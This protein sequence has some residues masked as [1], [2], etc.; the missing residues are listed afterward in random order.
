MSSNPGAAIATCANGLAQLSFASEQR[1][2]TGDGL[3][4]D[5]DVILN[6]FND[7][8]R[9]RRDAMRDHAEN[10]RTGN[11]LINE[12]LAKIDS[13]RAEAW[14]AVHSAMFM[15]TDEAD[16]QAEI[17]TAMQARSN[18]AR[19]RYLRA[20]ANAK[21]MAFLA[22]RSIEERLGIYLSEMT[23]DLP[24]VEAPATWEADVCSMSGVDFAAF[25]ALGDSSSSEG[26][27]GAFADE[28]IGDYVTRLENVVES[29]PLVHN[30]NTGSD[31]A[32][33]S[34]R[35]DIVQ[36]KLP[37]DVQGSNLLFHS[38]DLTFAPRVPDSMMDPG[39]EGWVM[40]GCLDA[41]D[42]EM[43]PNCIRADV[44]WDTGAAGQDSPFGPDAS[45]GQAGFTLTF[46][47]EDCD[48]N[49]GQ[50]CA[51]EGDAVLRQDV[52]LDSGKY[53]LSWYSEASEFVEPDDLVY[54]RDEAGSRL[55]GPPT[56]YGD[57]LVPSSTPWYR[58]Y[59]EFFVPQRQSVSIV[60]AQPAASNGSPPNAVKIA[61][62]M[63]EEAGGA[64]VGS[65]SVVL[66]EYSPT[67]DTRTVRIAACEDVS[68]SAFKQ[69]W[70]YRCIDIC[71]GGILSSCGQDAVSTECFYELPFSLSLREMESGNLFKSAGF[72]K[73][74]FNYRFDTVAVNF[75]GTGTRNCDGMSSASCFTAGFL[76][77]SLYHTGPYKV[78]NHAG[79][80]FDSKLFMGTIEHARGLASERVVT[81]PIS[82]A[83]RGLL[84]DYGRA[85]LRGRP[86]N[87]TFTLRVW[88]EP[89]VNFQAIE[90]VQL[91][92]NYRYWT[93]FN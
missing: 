5:L 21:R 65:A 13:L 60:I 9:T 22:K 35:D 18:V 68:G 66:R 76:P 25:Q 16:A 90:D 48:P 71:P 78:R 84:Q 42:G 39:V 30:F 67:S 57:L 33:V 53:L 15:N 56:V 89:G 29:Y 92:L 64:P 43:L 26:D 41:S 91:V 50:E 11:E 59:V 73:G 32:V 45:D 37:C 85:E 72:A 46:G 70:K 69:R 93:R 75:V 51:F 2:L 81:N 82:S 28:F 87:G 23:E 47:D 24:L 8:V 88:D 20:H 17:S 14:R 77:Y 7:F 40:E 10:I 86:F 79:Q 12:H 4:I 44:A 54:V 49:A 74:N 19:E 62:L 52:M 80:T 31:T 55:T 61:A 34:M 58:R 27:L 38:G 1:D 63:L 83:D 6:R 36:E 3:D